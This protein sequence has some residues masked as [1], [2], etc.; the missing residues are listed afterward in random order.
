MYNLFKKKL[1]ICYLKLKNII[2]IIFF[3][4]GTTFSSGQ[5]I[6]LSFSSNN[7]SFPDT[8]SMGDTIWYNCWIV[9]EGNSVITDHIALRAARL[10]QPNYQLLVDEREIGHI[11]SG[12]LYPGDSIELPLGMLHEVVN[13]QNYMTGDNIVVIWP[14]IQFPGSQANEHFTT[15]IYVRNKSIISGINGAINSKENCFYF[16]NKTIHFLNKFSVSEVVLYNMLGNEVYKSNYASLKK[17]NLQNINI[18]TYLVVIRLKD[19]T[20]R[21]EK[22]IVR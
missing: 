6:A 7:I 20:I 3:V 15:Q 18:G 17:V 1:Y 16:K 5:N 9:N 13:Q 21:K 10:C 22:L 8:I 4:G 11:N 12:A 14:R 19:G 2:T